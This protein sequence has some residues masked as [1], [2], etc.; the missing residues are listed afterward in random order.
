[1]NDV[2]KEKTGK[3]EG[4][5][6]REEKERKEG[7]KKKMEGRKGKRKGRKRQGRE[8]RGRERLCS[9]LQ[10]PPETGPT[11][12]LQNT[13]ELSRLK[14]WVTICMRFAFNLHAVC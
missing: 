8:K 6:E 3:K 5:K 4:R 13:P 11:L 10:A 2:K 1:M 9:R 12:L 14:K 7:R